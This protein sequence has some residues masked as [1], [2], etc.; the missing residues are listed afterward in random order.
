[1]VKS[2]VDVEMNGAKIISPE[3]TRA[4]ISE[5]MRS[6]YGK[7]LNVE[8][9]RVELE[10]DLA[11]GKR[12]LVVE[13]VIHL[14][15]WFFSRRRRRFIYYVDAENGKNT[16]HAANEEGLKTANPIFVHM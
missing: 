7:K 13:G 1:M 3:E 8:F 6:I 16:D 4:I 10:T 5:R 12:F 2:R 11:D 9:M 14:R 15:R